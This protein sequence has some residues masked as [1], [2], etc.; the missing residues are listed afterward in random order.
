MRKTV[1]A[2]LLV[3]SAVTVHA[4]PESAQPLRQIE[5]GATV[6]IDPYYSYLIAGADQLDVLQGLQFPIQST[7]QAGAFEGRSDAAVFNPQWMTQPVFVLGSDEASIAWF[8]T[9]W[10]R[11]HAMDAVGIVIA[12]ADAQQFKRLQRVADSIPVTPAVGPF[13]QQ[14]LL[15]AG[16]STYPVLIDLDGHASAKPVDGLEIAPAANRAEIRP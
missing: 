16:V 8:K 10:R 4:Q 3:A 15:A 12:A 6:P 11:L 1:L 9:H 7:L 13:V 2:L 5:G 14:Q